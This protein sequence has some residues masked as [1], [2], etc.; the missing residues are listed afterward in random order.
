MDKIAGYSTASVNIVVPVNVCL[1][2]VSRCV[3]VVMSI[4]F[5]VPLEPVPGLPR[6]C[7]ARLLFS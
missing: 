5:V 1:F 2:V 6:G 7:P 3:R 4:Y